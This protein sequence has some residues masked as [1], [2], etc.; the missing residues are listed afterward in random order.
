MI[1][2]GVADML[3][4][5]LI[6]EITNQVLKHMGYLK[7]HILPADN[8][9]FGDSSS[10][11]SAMPDLT[12]KEQ[13]AIPLL[14]DPQD[15][16]ALIRMM[17]RT[18]ARI[19]VGR[20]GPRN[21]TKTMLTLRADHAIARDAVFTDVDEKLLERLGLFSVQT[22]CRDKNEH[23]T[24]PDL[25]RSLDQAAAEVVR[26]KCAKDKDVQI[27]ASDGISSKAIQ[28]NLE[29]ILPAITEGLAARGVTLGQPFFV[30]FGRV[31]VE[32]QIAEIL[33][34]KVVCILIGE[35]PGLATAESM[36]A[37]ICYNAKVGQPEARRTVVS[38]IHSG[39]ISSVEA[40]AYISEL[41]SKILDRKAS[42]VD[43]QQ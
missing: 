18:A 43:L 5:I 38:N 36:S 39:G 22:R 3:D 4:E 12:S 35:R 30:K 7:E 41:I 37:Y 34:A 42:G 23:I 32:D 10:L 11:E 16:E 24:R 29:N 2:R 8:S 17:S 25:G 26:S 31:A 6:E 21:K 1:E 9:S 28:A 13:K 20:A 15:R 40:G 33:N 27:I 19:G 14:E